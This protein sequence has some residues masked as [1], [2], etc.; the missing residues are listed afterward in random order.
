MKL[1]EL[2]TD[3]ISAIHSVG[4]AQTNFAFNIKNFVNFV[5]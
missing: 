3:L 2:Q 5:G 1:T 4:F